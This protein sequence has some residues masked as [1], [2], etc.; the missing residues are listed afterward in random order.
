MEIN[1]EN[2]NYTLHL[3]F[4]T[5]ILYIKSSMNPIMENNVNI[6]HIK[7]WGENTSHKTSYMRIH[8]E[9]YIQIYINYLIE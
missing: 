9:K 4:H 3:I 6:T 8:Q 1:N 7:L 2:E 5:N